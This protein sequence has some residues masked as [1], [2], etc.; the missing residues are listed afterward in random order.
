[1]ER[2][3]AH[4]SKSERAQLAAAVTLAKKRCA[5]AEGLL[6]YCYAAAKEETRAKQL[7]ARL[8][9]RRAPTR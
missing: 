7:V 1:V 3:Y 4:L 9:R 8:K 6:W 5:D 2:A